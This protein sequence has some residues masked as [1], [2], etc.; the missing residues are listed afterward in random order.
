ME[1]NKENEIG[2][3]VK[4]SI[5]DT[6]LSSEINKDASSITIDFGGV[7]QKMNSEEFLFLQAFL[8][9]IAVNLYEQEEENKISEILANEEAYEAFGEKITFDFINVA[10]KKKS[11]TENPLTPEECYTPEEVAENIIEE[12]EHFEEEVHE[13]KSTPAVDMSNILNFIPTEEIVEKIAEE[14]KPF[15]APE[16]NEQEFNEISKEVFPQ[17]ESPAEETLNE[18][19][20]NTRK[21]VVIELKDY[22]SLIEREYADLSKLQLTAELITPPSDLK[23]LEEFVNW[24]KRLISEIEIESDIDVI[25]SKCST[26]KENY[27][28]AITIHRKQFRLANPNAKKALVQGV[29]EAFNNFAVEN[30]VELMKE[31]SVFLSEKEDVV[32]DLFDDNSGGMKVPEMKRLDQE[33]DSLPVSTASPGISTPGTP[34]TT[35]TGNAYTGV[36]SSIPAPGDEEEDEETKAQHETEQNAFIARME[37][38]ENMLTG[39]FELKPEEIPTFEKIE[40]IA[41]DHGELAAKEYVSSLSQEQREELAKEHMTKMKEKQTAGR[42]I[43]SSNQEVTATEEITP[44]VE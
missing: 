9:N 22:A 25:S 26:I 32:P 1:S 27:V 37:D 40:Q 24:N 29:F 19:F 23:M 36:H 44:V 5:G 30:K 6:S 34:G 39:D 4:A 31:Y 15:I 13:P 7:S 38:L 42:Q 17:E 35:G 41:K 33:D 28:E 11:I 12:V 8:N 3:K 14:E 10:E 43:A 18:E 21:A 20:Q 2:F 16:I